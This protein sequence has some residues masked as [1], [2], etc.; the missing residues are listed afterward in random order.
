M[1][2]KL[3]PEE[4]IS[5]EL[6][7]SLPM[8]DYNLGYKHNL[9]ITDEDIYYFM[10]RKN[11]LGEEAKK[12]INSKAKAKRAN[13]N[14]EQL[15]E[16]S[17]NNLMPLVPDSKEFIPRKYWCSFD[18]LLGSNLNNES[19]PVW[20]LSHRIIK[21]NF[22]KHSDTMLLQACGNF[23]PYIDSIIYQNNLKLYREGYFDLFVSSW[24]LVP[25]DFSCFFPWRFYDWNHAKETSFMTDVCI[26]HEFRNICDF[27]EYFNYKRLIIYAP[28]GDD[29]FYNELNRRLQNHFENSKVEVIMIWD[30][31]T[32]QKLKDQGVNH[33]GIIK[34]R[35]HMLRPGRDKLEKLIGYAPEKSLKEENWWYGIEDKDLIKWLRRG[36]ERKWAFTP[37][38][39]K[40]K[41]QQIN[42]FQKEGN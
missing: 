35:Y 39:R 37:K 32:I 31:E 20:Q 42:L 10:G 11:S 7:I 25:I 3:K 17:K 34:S 23:K 1:S 28:G 19:H 6:H 26:T 27:V 33:P 15:I 38:P 9:N 16:W 22:V 8:A 13:F 36:K 5:K 18:E 29:Y 41:P 24:E 14:K 12:Q 40:I 21:D 4:D 2:L 30:E